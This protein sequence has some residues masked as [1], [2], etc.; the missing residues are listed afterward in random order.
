M[1]KRLFIH[2]L[3]NSCENKKNTHFYEKL[4][5]EHLHLNVKITNKLPKCILDEIQNAH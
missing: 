4:S 2:L 3:D 1:H 5:T